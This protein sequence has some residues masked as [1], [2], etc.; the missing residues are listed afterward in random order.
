MVPPRWQPA[1]D[2]RPIERSTIP[3]LIVLP[4]GSERRSDS[5]QARCHRRTGVMGVWSVGMRTGALIMGGYW[6]ISVA[7]ASTVGGILRPSAWAVLMLMT[8]SNSVGCSTGI[9]A[10]LAPFRILS[11]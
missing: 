8:S 3:A 9:S 11:T 7:W 5:L 10:G 6:M 2:R 4:T 1:S